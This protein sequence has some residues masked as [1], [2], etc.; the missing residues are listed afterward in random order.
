MSEDNFDKMTRAPAAVA[1]T[2]TARAHAG[3]GSP[4]AGAGQSAGAASGDPGSRKQRHGRKPM[5]ILIIVLACVALLL[6]VFIGASSVSSVSKDTSF[7]VDRGDG[8][9][10][11]ADR[12][13]DRGLISSSFV[14]KLTSA[15][16][17]AGGQWQYGRHEIPA[18]S[19]CRDIVKELTK[20]ATADIKVTIPEGLRVSQIG[21]RLEKAGVCDKADFMNECRTGDFDYKFLKGIDTEKRI[22]GLEGYLFPDTYY[23]DRDT[24]PDKVI[25]AMLDEFQ[26]NVYTEKIRNKAAGMG[27]S[28]DE[29]VRLASVVES[30]A[31]TEPD[32][33]TIAGVFLNRLNTPGYGKLQS[34]VT[35]EYAKG[36][37]KS[38]LSKADTMYDSPYNTYLYPGLPYGPICCPGLESINAVLNHD[39]NDYYFFQ[40]DQ[41]G[42][43]YFAKTYSEHAAIQKKVQAAWTDRVE[44]RIS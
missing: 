32:R 26:D 2:G 14:F 23:F 7:K 4:D 15:V 24:D 40:S 16:S 29:L 39:D 33:K 44:K 42:N 25:R 21:D 9:L 3:T 11:L 13:A 27:Y 35:V 37:K 12:L 6:A 1:D 18:G 17:G 34:C 31:A 22:N 10:V 19:D 5:I 38:V 20:P 43:L 30:E 41:Y 36:I 28:V 8:T